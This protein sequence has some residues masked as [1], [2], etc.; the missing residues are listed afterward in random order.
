MSACAPVDDGDQPSD[1]DD[2]ATPLEAYAE[3]DAAVPAPTPPPF[4]RVY[5][6]ALRVHRAD[7]GLSGANL[8]AVLEEVNRIWWKQAAICFEIEVVN[9][10]TRRRD[11]FDLWYHRAKLG[12][13]TNANGVYCGDHD[14]HSLDN[15][16][17][18]PTNTPRWDTERNP[19]RTGAHELG[20]AL[21]L[22]HYNGFPDSN[23][24]LMSS[25]RQGFKLSTA[26]VTAARRR[27]ELKALPNTSPAPCAPVPVVE[28]A[29]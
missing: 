16:S 5:R 13:N 19:A 28:A 15:P 7:S 26:E 23:D 27:A 3:A 6:I 18:G 14:I 8:A 9:H 10:E 17:L 22:A 25:G 12:C 4:A 2:E 20:H 24:S 1:L 11:G 21:G 29:R